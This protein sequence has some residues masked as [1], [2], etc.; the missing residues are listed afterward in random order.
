[1]LDLIFDIF[2]LIELGFRVVSATDSSSLATFETLGMIFMALLSLVEIG[3]LLCHYSGLRVSEDVFHYVH[4]LACFRSLRCLRTLARFKGPQLLLKA[5]EPET[6]LL[7]HNFAVE[8]ILSPI[9]NPPNTKNLR[10]F[11]LIGGYLILGNPWD[12]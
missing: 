6:A 8:V 9:T 1:M 7:I 2:F 5:A 10:W 11:L 12:P 3:M 4:A